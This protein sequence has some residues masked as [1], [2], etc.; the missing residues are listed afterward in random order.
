MGAGS[1]NEQQP[2]A[3]TITP[4]RPAANDAAGASSQR[5]GSPPSTAAG[6]TPGPKQPS[7]RGQWQYSA[8]DQQSFH[9][10]SEGANERLEEAYKAS[11]QSAEVAVG[12][13]LY[14][15]EFAFCRMRKTSGDAA[16]RHVRRVVVADDDDA[17]GLSSSSTKLFADDGG[18]ATDNASGGGGGGVRHSI[19]GGRHITINDRVAKGLPDSISLS[20][21]AKAHNS[22][23]YCASFST[24]GKTIC[25]GGRDGTLRMWE[26]D[27]GFIVREFDPLN[28]VVLN[29]SIAP[30]KN[31]VA[32]G[33]DDHNLRLYTTASSTSNCLAGHSHK[34]YGVDFTCDS[35]AVFTASMDRTN[36]LWDVN[37]GKCVHTFSVHEAAAFTV[38]CSPYSPN[39]CVSGGD[40]NNVCIFD[41]RNG[42]GAA[43]ILK[44]HSAT[45]WAVDISFDERLIASSGMDSRVLLWDTRKTDAPLCTVG[46]HGKSPVHCV[47]F[48]DA[49]RRLITCGR[50]STW[51]AWD[52]EGAIAGG[53]EAA[54]T[55]AAGGGP[56]PVDHEVCRVHAHDGVVF[57][58]GYSN[59]R[60]QVVSIGADACIRLWNARL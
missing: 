32:S 3:V 20:S 36:K 37:R 22:L 26:L 31:M 46:T 2:S 51:R 47:E 4:A 14:K 30:G 40:D 28:A 1:S 25:T 49:G 52:V 60:S 33:A 24:D 34:V 15:V 11:T 42:D 29:C 7:G 44:G 17:T 19:D 48:C 35:R 21:T 53:P 50:D 56:S 10:F 8:E 57:G 27:T 45:L 6:V 23:V 13:Q 41:L 54:A 5:Q 12:R 55:A 16:P 58:V 18:D 39:M 38:K 9:D 59:A 43:A